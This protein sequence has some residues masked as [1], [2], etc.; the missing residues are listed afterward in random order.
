MEQFGIDAYHVQMILDLGISFNSLAKRKARAWDKNRWTLIQYL[1]YRYKQ[2]FG[3]PRPEKPA[4]VPPLSKAEKMKR[5]NGANHPT[6]AH[7]FY[8]QK[9]TVLRQAREQA[10]L[11]I[12]ELARKINLNPDVIETLEDSESRKS[13]SFETLSE[14]AKALG[15][16]LKVD[17]RLERASAS[18]EKEA[19]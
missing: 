12:P 19:P 13:V 9:A 5:T 16:E 17:I 11:G 3:K 14:I 1:E 7:P 18:E 2:E 10:G 15:L 4:F 6:P 8:E